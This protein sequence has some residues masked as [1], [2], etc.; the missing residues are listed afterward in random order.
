MDGIYDN[1]KSAKVDL[2]YL[3]R[4]FPEAD[5]EILRDG[6]KLNEEQLA[7]DIESCEIQAFRD[8]ETKLPRTYR[9]G[10]GHR[11]DDVAKGPD[12]TP[13]KAWGPENPEDRHE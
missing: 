12:E 5:F 3:R 10:L 7:A 9:H 1:P 6:T 11:T 4:T 8:G 2:E 13:V